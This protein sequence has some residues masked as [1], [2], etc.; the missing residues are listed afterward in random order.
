[1]TSF[2]ADNI[3]ICLSYIQIMY[4]WVFHGRNIFLIANFLLG[5]KVQMCVYT[6]FGS[7]DL[8]IATKQTNFAFHYIID[9][10]LGWG[11]RY[12]NWFK[13]YAKVKIEIGVIIIWRVGDLWN[14]HATSKIKGLF[15]TYPNQFHVKRLRISFSH[16]LILYKKK[17]SGWNIFKYNLTVNFLKDLSRS[18]YKWIT[19]LS[20]LS[21]PPLRYWYWTKP[22]YVMTHSF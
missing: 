2:C 16:R 19:I 14:P 5:L 12:K 9:L 22:S 17:I 21:S 15:S 10:K 1:M 11:W 6:L 18:L 3:S 20:P 4:V 7:T 13:K 8:R